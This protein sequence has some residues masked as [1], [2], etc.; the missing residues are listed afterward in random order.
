MF[1]TDLISKI[2]NFRVKVGDKLNTLKS[3]IGQLNLLTTNDK[4]SLVGA[5][6]EVNSLLPTVEEF[7]NTL[8][9][10][11]S[12]TVTEDF[13]IV[14][15]SST[16]KIEPYTFVIR[17]ELEDISNIR[18]CADD[19]I[20][21]QYTMN[22]G[23][24]FTSA[25]GGIKG[26]SGYYWSLLTPS[27][28][29]SRML[30]PITGIT[31][32]VLTTGTKVGATT[33]YANNQGVIELPE[34]SEFVKNGKG[35]SLKYRVDNQSF[36]GVIGDKAI[37]VSY[38]PSANTNVN[39]PYGAI[40]MYS[41]TAGYKNSVLGLG[42]T[43][44]GTSNSS[45]GQTNHIIS[46]RSIITEDKGIVNK[47]KY[48]NGI[49]AGELNQINNSIHSVILGGSENSIEGEAEPRTNSSYN[50]KNAI[51]GGY[52]NKIIS[53]NGTNKQ[54]YGSVIFGGENNIAQGYYNMIAGYG[55]HAVTLGETL[56]GIYGTIQNTSLSGFDFIDN[57][58]IFNV[59]VGF[60]TTNDNIRRQDG[61]S[62][63]R[64]GLVTAP[65]A[66]NSNIENNPKA[67]TTKEFVDNK[68]SNF[69]LPTNWT[70]S[71]QRFSGLP[72][73]TL[74][75]TYKRILV[76][77]E[78]GN[79]G[80]NTD[81]GGLVPVVVNNRT[82][83]VLKTR[84]DRSDLFNPNI[85]ES[86]IE[87]VTAQYQ[88]EPEKSGVTGRNSVG[89]GN[90]TIVGTD[91][92]VALGENAIIRKDPNKPRSVSN[93]SILGK[94]TGDSSV[95]IGHTSYTVGDRNIAIG[96]SA[97]V[98]YAGSPVNDSIV[99]G[100]NRN[101]FASSATVV[102]RGLN[103]DSAYGCSTLGINNQVI[104]GN[105]TSWVTTDPVFMIG[106]GETSLAPSNALV[107]LK[108]GLTTLPSVTN[109]LIDAN[110]KAVIT[111]EYLDIR[112]PKPPTTGEYVLKSVDGVVSWVLS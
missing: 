6:N 108:N 53:A 88:Y 79:A 55:N 98:G 2:T 16:F 89:I 104:N 75:S 54:S 94:I 69:S 106:N 61:L 63:F 71:S 38:T 87:I 27:T 78:N 95:S 33:Y 23:D 22:N 40:G 25:V 8:K 100:N 49:F 11:E 29:D 47:S 70:N 39:F 111:K 58:R 102:G 19:G 66:S 65:T 72:N 41:F 93:I 9:K 85:G 81:L 28:G 32:R 13:E 31:G 1:I 59:G 5:V 30:M 97:R 86:S 15:D 57:S 36:Y 105:K 64:N 51:I 48:S 109:T 99:I 4:T 83:Y 7:T 62:V 101:E 35:W 68:I 34:D 76:L 82:S 67:V 92:S 3:Q 18:L 12:N 44:L 84:F 96:Y 42:S 17:G 56:V 112:I 60:S 50:S 110:N 37:D 74:D 24:Y 52:K 14:N 45:S 21:V 90:H 77:D 91:N 10:N 46:Y 20:A 26:Q 80:Y 43:V 73:K 103:G 107:I